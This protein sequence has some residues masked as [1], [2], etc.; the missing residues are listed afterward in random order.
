MTDTSFLPGATEREDEIMAKG[1]GV[2]ASGAERMVKLV[3][4]RS[5]F[6]YSP[7]QKV[8]PSRGGGTKPTG[9]NRMAEPP[10]NKTLRRMR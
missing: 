1:G 8:N 2:S 7:P 6:S 5:G 9:P 3:G 10:E 4:K